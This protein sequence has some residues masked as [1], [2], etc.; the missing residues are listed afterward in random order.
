M[1]ALICK[2]LRT[3]K[4]NNTR[5]IPTDTLMHCPV[6]SE[7]MGTLALKGTVCVNASTTFTETRHDVT[8]IDICKKDG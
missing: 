1:F 4:R 3:V 6:V 8:F 5:Q 7:T 2:S